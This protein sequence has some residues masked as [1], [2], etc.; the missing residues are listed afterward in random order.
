MTQEERN[1]Y[2]EI[3]AEARDQFEAERGA[4][5]WNDTWETILKINPGLLKAYSHMSSKPHRKGTLDAKTKGMIYVA[6]DASITHLYTTGMGGHIRHGIR[7]LGITEEEMVEVLAITST[8]GGSTW[9]KAFPVLTDA[10]KLQGEDIKTVP[11]TDSQKAIK[12]HYINLNG[13]W[14]D[15]WDDILKLDEEMFDC[16]VAYL[17]ASLKKGAVDMKTR[18]LIL[19]A[20]FAS[21]TTLD[22]DRMKIHLKRAMKL[23]AT[24]EEILEILEIVCCLGIHSVTVGVPLV[25][26]AVSEMK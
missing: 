4:W 16:Y 21:P 23:G 8:V 18:E 20:V 7:D 25:N 11:L 24:K 15:D 5:K 17:E 22:R 6:I 9:T 1:L 10:L 3:Q 26:E 19:V 14:D 2:T 12:E 13:Y